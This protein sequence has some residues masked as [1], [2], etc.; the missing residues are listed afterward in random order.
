M[1]LVV[2]VFW[3]KFVVVFFS[4]TMVT[5]DTDIALLAGQELVIEQK[6]SIAFPP[7]TSIPHNFVS[8]NDQNGFVIYYFVDHWWFV[9]WWFC[10]WWSLFE[11]CFDDDHVIE[12]C[13]MMIVRESFGDFME[14]CFDG[15]WLYEMTRQSWFNTY[16]EFWVEIVKE[17]W[18]LYYL[19]LVTYFH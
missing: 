1:E 3:Y 14:W 7:T 17:Q 15:G 13:F 16:I 19:H 11:I 10:S 18:C 12:K 5:W 8:V 6:E 2:V 9:L 4:N